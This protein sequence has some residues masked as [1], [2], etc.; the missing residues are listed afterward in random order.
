MDLFA[1]M[2][3]LLTVTAVF[4]WVNH[5]TLKLPT[6]IGVMLIA[7]VS[8]LALILLHTL[9]LDVETRASE[10]IE[11]IDFDRTVLGGML[12]FLLFA[13]AL[14]V[15]LGSLA[16]QKGMI[17]LLATCGVVL[18]TAIVGVLTFFT[19]GML[20]LD[21]PWI[22]CF[23][24]GALI[25]PTDPIAVLALLKKARVPKSLEIKIVGESLFNDG[26]GVVVFLVL[27]HGVGDGDGLS[28][29]RG[30][31]L[32]VQEAIGGSLYGLVVGW[33][34]FQMLRRVDD[35]HVEV[36]VT[37]ALVT[38]S[39]ALAATLHL[40]GPIAI[41]VAGLYIGTHGR[42]YAMSDTTRMHLDSFWE[43]LDNIL[44]AVLFVLIG[45]E[46]LVISFASGGLG[47]GV[48]AIG[49]VLLSRFLS[50]GGVVSVLHRFRKFSPGVV[51]ILTWGGLR[52]GISV[53]LALGLPRGPEREIVLVA[54]Y[55]VVIF[56][57]VVQGLTVGK[58]ASRVSK[59]GT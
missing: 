48:I 28:F 2:A 38:G 16:E 6:T 29:T 51:S 3:A 50:V 9:G 11:S 10:I 33:I 58:L 14:H 57:I 26:V 12:A 30:G 4:S 1:L 7:L 15:D 43:L 40:S 35:R 36:L 47:L 55:A 41:V 19:A 42:R 56:S 32:F 31:L 20:G 44:N 49:I 27:L 21:L 18:S 17:A 22:Y 5:Q 13:G 37:L 34:A 23:L 54:T 25:S 45:L 52:G 53:A 59:S 24:F 46:V 39:Y 8:S